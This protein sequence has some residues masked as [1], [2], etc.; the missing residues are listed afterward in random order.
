MVGPAFGLEVDAN[1]LGSLKGAQ[2]RSC[3]LP[4]LVEDP[5]EEVAAVRLAPM[6]LVEDGEPDARIWRL[7]QQRPVGTVAVVMLEVDPEADP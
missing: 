1:L 3:S 6:I 5:T 4:V 2:T 7:Q